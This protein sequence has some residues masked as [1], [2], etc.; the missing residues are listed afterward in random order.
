MPR[1]PILGFAFAFACNGKEDDS[2]GESD[3]D[4]DTDADSDSDTDADSDT[5]TDADS[6]TD[7]DADSDTDTDTD[8][9][10]VAIEGTLDLQIVAGG[11]TICDATIDF[12]GIPFSGACPTCD[13][14]FEVDSVLS[15]DDGTDHCMYS[16][17]LLYSP[18]NRYTAP[19]LLGFAAN[20]DAGYYGMVGPSVFVGFTY[21]Y[22][23]GS[24]FT[25]DPHYPFLYEGGTFGYASVALE[26]DLL[27]W[28]ISLS[29]IP[30][31]GPLYFYPY[32]YIP[33]A[34][35]EWDSGSE[36]SAPYAAGNTTYGSLP[37]GRNYIDTFQFLG[38]A[39]GTAYATVDTTGDVASIDP[40]MWVY[41][42][43]SCIEAFSDDNFP[44]AHGTHD[45]PA[46]SIATDAVVY[47]LVV[48]SLSDCGTDAGA[49][50]GYRLDLD[51]SWDPDIIAIADDMVNRVTG[52]ASLS[53]SATLSK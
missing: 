5:D 34:F 52:E 53:A 16:P 48:A 46:M 10:W 29:K 51:T 36:A 13:F 44:C 28:G 18:S 26:D 40:A 49:E 6:D 33:P 38:T 15:R 3:A 47:T 25:Y 21:L 22:E 50:V 11:M 43:D 4:A 35:C 8:A 9:A 37:C 17:Q 42:P 12:T 7:T 1:V 20:G 19:T 24:T 30:G 14:V 23:D 45:C 27:T 41:S 32:D 31:Y 39:G 2:T